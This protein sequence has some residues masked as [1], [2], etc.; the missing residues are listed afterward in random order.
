MARACSVLF[1][2]ASS[3]AVSARSWYQPR[4]HPVHELFNRQNV[5]GGVADIGSAAWTAQYPAD[6]A[7]ASVPAAWKA[8]Y[9]NAVN[10]GLIPNI[11]VTT[12]GTDGLAKYPEGFDALSPTV[13]A[14]AQ[15]CRIN[16]SIPQIWDA[17]PGYAGISFDD[18]PVDLP[19]ASDLYAF[20][21]ENHQPSTHFLIGS[22]ILAN[23]DS[24][25][26]LVQDPQQELACHTWTH[27]VMTTQTDDQVLLELG[28]TLKIIHDSTGGRVP[29]L[30]RPPTGDSDMRVCA[31]AYHVFGLT[32][33]IW[34]Y[35]SNDW[36][37]GAPDATGTYTDESV[38]ASLTGW[39]NGP[40][41]PGLLMLEH[42]LN[43]HTVGCFKD[44]Y[45]LHKANNWISTTVSDAIAAPSWYQNSLNNTAPVAALDVAAPAPS[46]VPSPHTLAVT[47]STTPPASAPSAATTKGSSKNASNGVSDVGPL[48]MISSTALLGALLCSVAF[49]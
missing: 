43:N 35:D 30:W 36:Q 22:N 4:G 20:L 34:N 37:I 2:L 48:A 10:A 19:T 3:L 6:L 11:P 12:L 18:G 23:P 28:W 42:E 16:G 15:E 17:T 21:K 14:S 49:W 5:G 26:Q 1:L 39:L 38:T 32:T 45:S 9:T 40:K 47:T 24:F 33:V 44:T 27:P 13:C 25:K 46:T 8:A 31:I 29:R 41:T 7:T